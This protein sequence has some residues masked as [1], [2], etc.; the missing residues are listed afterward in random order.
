MLTSNSSFGS[1]LGKVATIQAKRRFLR[2]FMDWITSIAEEAKAREVKDKKL[3][4]IDAYI[5][6]RIPNIGTSPVVVLAGTAFSIPDE[7]MSQPDMS[8]LVILSS[9]ITTYAN[10]SNPS[11]P[12]PRLTS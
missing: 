6:N 1:R 10:V 4:T 11:S 5:T 7:T 8:E 12:P 2:E 9:K 3:L